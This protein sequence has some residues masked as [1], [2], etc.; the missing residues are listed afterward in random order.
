MT[1]PTDGTVQPVISIARKTPIL[2]SIDHTYITCLECRFKGT[3]QE[4]SAGHYSA[5][6]DDAELRIVRLDRVKKYLAFK[7]GALV[8]LLPSNVIT[9][10]EANIEENVNIDEQSSENPIFGGP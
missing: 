6:G 2:S 1:N 8:T 10:E 4:D 5:T 7:K 9:Y 3:W